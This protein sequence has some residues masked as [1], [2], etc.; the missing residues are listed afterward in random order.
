MPLVPTNYHPNTIRNVIIAFLSE[1]RNIQIEVQKPGE[2][3]ILKTIT[4]P[5]QLGKMEKYHMLN[6]QNHPTESTRYYQTL[7]KMA[8][9]WSSLVYN[10]QRARGK[11]EYIQYYTENTLLS[12]ATEFIDNVNPTPFDFGFELEIRTQDLSQFSQIIESILPYYNT[13]RYL[14]VKEFSFLN[15]ERDLPVKLEGISPDFMVEQT[16]E[17]RRYLNGVL[18]FTVE[19]HLYRPLT[20]SKVIKEIRTRYYPSFETGTSAANLSAMSGYNTSGWDSSASFPTN[21]YTFSG[22]NDGGTSGD[23]EYYSNSVIDW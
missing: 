2:T 3:D 16:E 6:L 18:S 23:S 8:L 14:R 12:D 22:T 7:P 11:D 4:V 21:A 19:A 17:N 20:S 10:G 1:F 5:V 15:V 13:N 9:T